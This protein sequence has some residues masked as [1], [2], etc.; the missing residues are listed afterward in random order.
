MARGRPPRRGARPPPDRSSRRQPPRDRPPGA[1][2]RVE[3]L[4][5]S[6]LREL[7]ELTGVAALR[8]SPR[9][10]ASEVDGHDL[11]GLAVHEELRQPQRKALDRRGEVVALWQLSRRTAEEA[12]GG[13]ARQPEARGLANVH[14]PGL[15]DRAGEPNARLGARRSGGEAGTSRRPERELA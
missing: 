14:N 1:A 9:V 11:V 7:D 5:M 4:V 10:A 2:G 15:G 3:V 8:G 13:P 12:L 6:D